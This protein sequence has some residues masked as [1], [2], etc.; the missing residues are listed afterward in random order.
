VL[1]PEHPDTLGSVNNLAALY[2][3][4][5]RYAEA[6]PLFQRGLRDRERVLG[7]EHP[8]TLGSVNN[9]AAL[10]YSQGRYAEAEPLY[11]RALR[12][13]ERVLGPEHPDTLASL[14]SLAGLLAR[15]GR[16]DEAAALIE[17]YLA[18]TKSDS[19][20]AAPL[21][22]RQLALE[23]YQEGDYRRAEQ[24]L[25]FV[26]ERHFEVASAHCHLARVLLLMDRDKEA[27]SEAEEAWANRADWQP[28]IGQRVYFLQ[29]LF[30]LL[31]GITPTEALQNL[32]TELLRPDSTMEW[33]LRSLLDHLRPRFTP[34][35]NELIEA[36]SAAINDRAAIEHL[37]TLPAWKAIL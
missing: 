24:L 37:E 17:E 35:G 20:S 27:R 13:R 7:P 18:R 16:V 22:F 4:Q 9:L 23:C 30:G 8:D 5:G 14:G 25:R 28:Y 26:L 3:S 12:D 36:L 19:A 2:Y 1:G 32:K 6:E 11:Q 15:A 21:A 33:D 31:D 10:Y 29:A 34:E